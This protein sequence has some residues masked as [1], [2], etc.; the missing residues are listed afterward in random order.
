MILWNLQGKEGG[1]NRRKE[2]GREVERGR[3]KENR[4]GERFHL[5]GLEIV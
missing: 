4:L 3:E 5:D 1:E 2:E